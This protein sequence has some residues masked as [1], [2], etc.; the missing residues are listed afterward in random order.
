[1]NRL[2]TLAM[3]LCLSAPA[4]ACPRIVSQAPY[5]TRTLQWL[6]LEPCIVGVGNYDTLD[7]PHT[8][9]V[10]DPDADAIAL[11]QPQ[12]MFNADW[13][14]E[15]RWQALAPPTARAVTLHGFL[16]MAE[17]EENLRIVGRAAQLDDAEARAASFA[18][19]WRAAAAQ[20]QGNGRRVLL[21][22]ACSGT[23]YSFGK[24]SWLHDLFTAAGFTVAEDAER[25][26]HL[27]PGETITDIGTL[28]D[29]QQAE[30]L[31][32]FERKAAQQCALIRPQRPLPI[33]SLD[34]ENFLH[35]APSLL[36]GL[37]ELQA[38]RAQWSVP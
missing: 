8:G 16:S 33:V 13:L 37:A 31:F 5:I 18:Q 20:V 34:G 30:V 6:G 12:L 36:E 29:R 17:V 26:R 9:G 3:L 10:L 11:L 22:S 7:L 2:L 27:R 15:A 4:A 25:L 38:K 24:N 19:A 1:M 32:V 23:P 21:L 14:E 35:P 28:A